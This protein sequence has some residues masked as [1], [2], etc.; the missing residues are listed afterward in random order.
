M[1]RRDVAQIQMRIFKII[2]CA[3]LAIPDQYFAI[4]FLYTSRIKKPPWI[5]PMAAFLKMAIN[6]G[7]IP[8]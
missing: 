2:S 8:P 5:Q 4:W 3:G 7:D 6:N 1:K